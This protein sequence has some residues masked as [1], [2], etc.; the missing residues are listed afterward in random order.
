MRLV[1][2]LPHRE[3][4]RVEEGD[5][6]L[7]LDDRAQLEL[8]ERRGAQVAEPIAVIAVLAALSFVALRRVRD[9]ARA[10]TCWAT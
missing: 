6:V 7:K 4:S 10:A 8:G 5:L 1:V 2:A 9:S 3:G